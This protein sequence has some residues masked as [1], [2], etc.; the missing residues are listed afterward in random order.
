VEA[1]QVVA[2]TIV[3]ERIRLRN[4]QSMVVKPEHLHNLLDKEL[5]SNS[6]KS[7]ADTMALLKSQTKK[8]RTHVTLLIQLP[9]E[10]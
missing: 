10:Q 8:T 6:S 3:L 5:I 1:I 2:V 7:G 4:R 9:D